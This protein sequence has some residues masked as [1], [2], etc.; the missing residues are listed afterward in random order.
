MDTKKARVKDAN[1]KIWVFEVP[2]SMTESQLMAIANDPEAQARITRQLNSDAHVEQLTQPTRD[3]QAQA[4]KLAQGAQLKIGPIN[5]GFDLPSW[6]SLPL[7]GVGKAPVDI[8][9][10]ISQR[11]GGTSYDDVK[12]QRKEDAPLMSTPSGQI[13]NFGGNAL[14]F[15]PAVM[16]GPGMAAQVATGAVGGFLQPA[17]SGSEIAGN[18]LG[19]AAASAV[20]PGVIRGGQILRAGAEPFSTAGQNRIMGRML[21][22]TAGMEPADLAQA[23]RANQSSIPGVQ[24]NAAE[25][26]QI[27]SLSAFA[28]TA[29][30]TDPTVVNALTTRAQ[31]NNAARVDALRQLAGTDGERDFTAASRQATADQLYGHAYNEGIDMSQLTPARRGEIT[32]L[33]KTPAI[34]QAV[35][36]AETMMQN[37]MKNSASPAGSV[38]GLHYVRKALSDQISNATGNQKRVLSDLLDRFDSTMDTISPAYAQARVEFAA[39]SKP[40]NAMDATQR[41]MDTSVDPLTGFLRPSNY[42]RNLND[43]T[44]QQATG[45]RGAT[46]DNTFEPGQ[47]GTLNAIG[48]DLRRVHGALNDGRGPG[49]DTV[50]KLAYSNLIDQAG[51]P[52]WLR[53]MGP[54]QTMGNMLARGGDVIYG[55]Q[56]RTMSNRLANALLSPEETATL[57][58]AAARQRSGIAPAL[59]DY[60]QRANMFLTP[61][62]NAL[63]Q[64]SQ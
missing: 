31:Q 6:A 41:L 59:A 36:D 54:A 48:D 30:A 64:N 45:F 40:L 46:L 56:N 57:L 58:D 21:A 61:S 27:P 63:V 19:G 53:N 11:F 18:T 32:K 1:G 16:A 62:A 7:A 14:M 25:A 4:E 26:A 20:I 22:N 5:T 23:L 15:A 12:Q 8:A 28:R 39:A 52:N 29:T 42:V 13:G 38:E 9:R 49:S 3:L 24:Y 37:S 35:N 43:K 33:L 51:F 55:S 60:T 2:A 34:Q 44:V 17:T 10:G 47:L 50:Q